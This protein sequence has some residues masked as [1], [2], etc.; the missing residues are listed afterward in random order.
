MMIEQSNGFWQ[1]GKL[2]YPYGRGINFQIEVENI[3]ELLQ[4]VKKHHIPLFKDMMI[5]T[6]SDFTQKEFLVQD[7][8]GYLLRFSQKK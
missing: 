8:D 7:P 5:N 3:E 4:N 6:Y 1:T 2:D